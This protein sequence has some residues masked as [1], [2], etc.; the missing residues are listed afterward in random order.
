VKFPDIKIEIPLSSGAVLLAFWL[1]WVFADETGMIYAG[2]PIR[3]FM[4]YL[5]VAMLIWKEVKAEITA[6]K[7]DLR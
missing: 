3:N 1:F 2:F 4:L 7:I 6:G 5:G